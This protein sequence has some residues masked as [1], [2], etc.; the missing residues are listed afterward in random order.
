MAIKNHHYINHRC[1]LPRTQTGAV[2]LAFM[3]VFIVASAFYLTTK[4][5]TNQAKT[6]H[7]V[8]TGIAMKAAKGALIGY[9]ISY[10]DKVNAASG[11]GYLPCPDLDNDGDAEGSC[12]LAGPTNW[13][14]GRLPFKTLELSELRDGSGARLWYALSDDYR[15]FAGL[16][17]LNSDTAGQLTV[18]GVGDIVAIVFAPG[19]P[20][21][22][23]DRAADAND[24]SN[25]LEDDNKNLD[26]NFVTNAGGN[27]NDR[28]VVITR[29]ELMEAVEKRVLG[30]VN[31]TLSDHQTNY[32][33]YP[34]LSVFSNPS[35]SKFRAPRDDDFSNPV[36]TYQGHLPFHWVSDPSVIVGVNPFD[37]KVTWS[38]D[39]NTG[40]ATINPGLSSIGV[41]TIGT[42]CLEELACTTDAVFPTVITSVTTNWTPG[43]PGSVDCTWTNKDT[44]DCDPAWV[45]RGPEV[46]DLGCGNANCFRAYRLAFPSFTG[47]TTISNPSSTDYRTRSVSY[48]GIMAAQVN[49]ISLADWY[50]G[51]NPA[52]LCS[53][54]F[55]GWHQISGLTFT[56]STQ[57]RIV[58]GGIQYDIDIDNNELPSWFIDNKWHHLIYIAYSTAETLPGG[59]TLC[60]PGT[61]CLVL[62]NSGA[63][64]GD[65][66]AFAIIAGEDLS[67]VVSP[68]PNGNLTDYFENQNSSPVDGIFEKGQITVNFNDQIRV[69]STSP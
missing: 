65:K 34:W 69:I 43:F 7:S 24:V 51:L 4:L 45:L 23:Q 38:W 42:D 50:D 2:L 25:Y 12:A 19:E 54:T 13:T 36:P 1:T 27:F 37:T 48:T 66:R 18:N 9:A 56:T 29:Q 41:S 59:A 44:A 35:T 8:E 31:Q 52:D 16:T 46:C 58:A 64:S 53:S 49:A 3:L 67:P 61:D 33:A 68:R 47:T 30:E 40:T 55:A 14:T 26:V 5:N 39:I 17:P 21:D 20:F 62:N 15:N 28:L 57:G 22:N 11:P 32:G 10:P 63:P 6:Q 60:I